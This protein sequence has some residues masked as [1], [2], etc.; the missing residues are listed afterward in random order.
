MANNYKPKAETQMRQNIAITPN[1]RLDGGYIYNHINYMT[2][3]V[4]ATPP[5]VPAPAPDAFPTVLLARF[6]LPFGRPLGRFV[7]PEGASG[8]TSFAFRFSPFT[9]RSRR[10][11]EQYVAEIV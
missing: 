10:Y 6:L 8:L 7:V 11:L 2:N 9:R 3:L 4:H 1:H 5:A